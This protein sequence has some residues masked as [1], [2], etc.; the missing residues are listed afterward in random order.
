V[1]VLVIGGGISGLASAHRLVRAG[2]EVVLAEAS[3]QLGGLGTFFEEEGRWIDRFYHCIMPSDDH[4]LRLI[5]EVGL[6]EQ[7]YWKPTRMGFVVNGR[8]YPFNTA[9][10]LLR[11]TPL[12]LAERVRFGL[13]S[14]LLRRLG[15]GKDLDGVTSAEWL[16]RWYGRSIWDKVWEPLYRSK[17]G[18]AVDEV[19]ALYIWSRLGREKNNSTRGYLRCGHR[20]LIDAIASSI[21]SGGGD[22][23]L[24]T[25][26]TKLDQSDAGVRAM[27]SD[28]EELEVDWVISTV[29]IPILLPMIGG[30]ALDGAL[31]DP[32]LEYQGVVNTLFFMRRPL[33]GYY[34]SPVLNSGTEFDAVIEMS[35]LVDPAQYGGFHVVYAVKYV[36]RE[37][38][39][40]AVDDETIAAHWAQQ[41]VA[42]FTSRGFTEDDIV[43]T[44]VFRAP[45]VEPAYRIGYSRVKPPIRAGSSRLLLATTAQVYPNI[46]SWNSSTRLAGEVIDLLEVEERKSST[47]RG[48]ERP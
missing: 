39:P 33:T 4:L 15:R 32:E 11:F 13:V 17:F 42:L 31:E 20:G 43:K 40:F 1:R 25:A 12:S 22:I 2:S 8:L 21:R 27:L 47:L 38:P 9:V 34:W 18:D 5:D 6:T 10:D 16:S 30:G 28:G 37:S 29:P 24:S 36:H 46:T 26:V 41:L 45:F 19:P 3:D 7:V 35:T 48:A 14:V 44:R 23:R